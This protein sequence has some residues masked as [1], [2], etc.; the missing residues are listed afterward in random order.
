MR[1]RISHYNQIEAE[2]QRAKQTFNKYVFYMCVKASICI[3][4]HHWL[5]WLFH[6]STFQL[7][8]ATIRARFMNYSSSSCGSFWQFSLSILAPKKKKKAENKKLT[9]TNTHTQNFSCMGKMENWTQLE[10]SRVET[11]TATFLAKSSKTATALRQ[12]L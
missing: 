2:Q 10:A 5:E 11:Q 9:S 12:F 1:V 7:L 3:L 8:P 6:F 4:N